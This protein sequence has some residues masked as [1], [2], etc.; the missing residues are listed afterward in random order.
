MPFLAELLFAVLSTRIEVKS[1]LQNGR[2]GYSTYRGGKYCGPGWGNTYQDILDGNAS[3]LEAA[4]DAIDEAC[5][6]HDTCYQ[7][8]GWFAPEKNPQGCNLVLSVS[9][10]KVAVDPKSTPQQRVDAFLMAA[11]F[12]IEANT[13]DLYPLT[14]NQINAM[15]ER[16]LG[17]WQSTSGTLEQ[18][19][20]HE[21]STR[22]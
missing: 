12:L 10:A 14:K 6:A 21:I 5:K 22:H 8:N 18:A 20:I 1:T 4:S 2:S 9:L 13:A 17:Y 19:I 15:R 16:V 3:K 11:I 7:D